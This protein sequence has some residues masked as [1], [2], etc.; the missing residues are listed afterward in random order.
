MKVIKCFLICAIFMVVF[1]TSLSA[2][3]IKLGTLVPNGSPWD[4][5]LKKLAAEW[6]RISVRLILR[7]EKPRMAAAVKLRG[8]FRALPKDQNAEHQDIAMELFLQQGVRRIT[9]VR[10]SQGKGSSCNHREVL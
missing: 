9:G 8:Q 7:L 1:T 4:K 10:L 3:T 2:L 6:A 5:N